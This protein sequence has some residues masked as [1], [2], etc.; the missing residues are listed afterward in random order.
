MSKIYPKCLHNKELSLCYTGHIL[1]CCWI[2][3]QF[4]ED[5]WKD[6]F[7]TEMNIDKFE[8]IDEIF[9]T[10]TWKNF[11]GMLKINPTNAPTRCKVM[12]YVPLNVDPEGNKSAVRFNK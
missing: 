1:P 10:E 7:S 8:T 5:E 4:N 11:F 12:C 9:E 3:D 6:F 2:N